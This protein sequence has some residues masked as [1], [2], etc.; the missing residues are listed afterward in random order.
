MSFPQP[1]IQAAVTHAR[2]ER[3]IQRLP[4]ELSEERLEAIEATLFELADLRAECRACGHLYRPY[5][6]RCS[7][8]RRP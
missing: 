8:C 2:I 3:V 6:E 1:P 7:S 4:E 5:I